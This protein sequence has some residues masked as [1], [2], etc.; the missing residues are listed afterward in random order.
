MTTD[1]FLY[2]VRVNEAQEEDHKA[3]CASDMKMLS[4]AYVSGL[5]LGVCF[6][7]AAVMLAKPV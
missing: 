2:I 6:I 5:L 4:V 1:D 7:M 3:I